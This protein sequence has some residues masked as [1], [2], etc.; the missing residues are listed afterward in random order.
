[1]DEYNKLKQQYEEEAKKLQQQYD[2]ENN[3]LQEK[4]KNKSLTTD[5]YITTSAQAIYD[6]INHGEEEKVWKNLKENTE[7]GNITLSDG[8]SFENNSINFNGTNDYLSIGKVN[9]EKLT[10][11]TVMSTDEIQS[12]EVELASNYSN[13]GYKIYLENG[14]IKSTVMIG[15]GEYS[16]Q[17]DNVVELNKKYYIAIL[18]QYNRNRLCLCL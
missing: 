1:M 10:I 12:G 3:N 18:R 15:N 8:K 16:L 17:S 13:G 4:I 2:K 5:D 7:L 9:P 14:K 6:G 11:E